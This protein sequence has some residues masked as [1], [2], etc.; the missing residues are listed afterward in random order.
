M[1]DAIDETLKVQRIDQTNRTDPEKRFPSEC[2]SAKNRKHDDECF[3]A[4]PKVVFRLIEVGSPS[5]HVGRSRLIKPA[6]VG[7]PEPAVRGT[8][9]VIRRVGFRVVQSMICCPVRGRT[10]TVENGPENEELLDNLVK[11]ER[12]VRQITVVTDRR[13]Q[14]SKESEYE[15]GNE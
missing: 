12:A 2:E 6:E 15:C 5:L 1:R 9:N 11:L 10:R 4:A 8:R 14:A 13:A 7:P 3:R